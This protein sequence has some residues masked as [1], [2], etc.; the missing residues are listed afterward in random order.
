MFV[1]YTLVAIIAREIWNLVEI[2][3]LMD[4]WRWDNFDEVIF[5]A[6]IVHGYKFKLQI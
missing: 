4:R 6:K 5:G 3:Y 1:Q 2:Y